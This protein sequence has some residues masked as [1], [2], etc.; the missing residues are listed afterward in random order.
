MLGESAAR[1]YKLLEEHKE[2]LRLVGAFNKVHL[3]KPDFLL[4]LTDALVEYETLDAN[5]RRSYFSVYVL[6]P[7]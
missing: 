6:T 5:V 7:N 4:Q 2:E 1:V 3:P